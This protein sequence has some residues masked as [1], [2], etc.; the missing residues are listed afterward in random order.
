MSARD[1]AGEPAAHNLAA[2]VEGMAADRNYREDCI[3]QL[4]LHAGLMEV[5]CSRRVGAENLF[6]PM[7]HTMNQLSLSSTFTAKRF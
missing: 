3:G 6:H 7:C 2:A 4:E 1:L 5:R